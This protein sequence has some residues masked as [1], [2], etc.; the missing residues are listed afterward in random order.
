VK[1]G[2]LQPVKS[3]V[4]R[5][6]RILPKRR[7]EMPKKLAHFLETD[8]SQVKCFAVNQIVIRYGGDLIGELGIVPFLEE[9]AKQCEILSHVEAVRFQIRILLHFLPFSCFES[10]FGLRTMLVVAEH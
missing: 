2:T 7:E 1:N 4:C 8:E 5:C 6:G 9:P 3:R 10:R